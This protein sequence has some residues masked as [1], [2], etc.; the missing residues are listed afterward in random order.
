[1]GGKSGG[2]EKVEVEK[3]VRGGK[4][5]LDVQQTLASASCSNSI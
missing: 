3:H 1:M 5:P 2:E 4:L